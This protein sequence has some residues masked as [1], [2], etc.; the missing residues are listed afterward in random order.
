MNTRRLSPLSAL[1]GATLLLAALAAAR[2]AHAAGQIELNWVEPQTFADIGRRPSDREA[3][4]REL[5]AHL[6]KLARRLPDGQTL[7]LTVTDLNLAGELEPHRMQELR[8][9]RGRADWPTMT[10]RYTL[11]GPGGPLRSGEARLSDMNYAFRRLRH[12]AE[13]LGYEKRMIDTWFQ[14]QILGP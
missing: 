3:T 4:L 6:H 7:K 10:L 8:I 5:A 9:L 2:P 1:A 12:P 13:D 14:E 11:A